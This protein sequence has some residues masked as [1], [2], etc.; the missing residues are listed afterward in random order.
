MEFHIAK[1]QE[2]VSGRLWFELR[3][4]QDNCYCGS[5]ERQDCVERQA[6]LEQSVISRAERGA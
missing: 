5:Y 1:T 6:E 2:V 4:E 3:D